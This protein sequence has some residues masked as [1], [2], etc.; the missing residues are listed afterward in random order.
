MCRTFTFSSHYVR[1]QPHSLIPYASI[2]SL[3]VSVSKKHFFF[4]YSIH[5]PP[6][7]AGLVSGLLKWMHTATTSILM[8]YFKYSSEFLLDFFI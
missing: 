3:K 4:I 2:V 6:R 1:F 5:F 7:P 8:Y